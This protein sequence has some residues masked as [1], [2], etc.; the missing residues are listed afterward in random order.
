MKKIILSI[1]VLGF[2]LNA[3][4]Q[5]EKEP[6]ISPK[7]YIGLHAGTTTGYGLSYRYWPTKLGVELTTA[8]K[9]MPGNDYKISAGLS[10]LYTVLE[11]KYIGLYSYLGNSILSSNEG[12]SIYDSNT[13]ISTYENAKWTQYNIGL[14]MGFKVNL[15]KELDFNVQTGYGLYDITNDLRTN[16]TGE[17]SMYYH[18]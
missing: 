18:F 15:F 12:Y 11:N 8:P 7:H 6:Y 13:G 3:I 17:I 4:A 16:L 9:F 5:D 1:L 14:G 2:A 10:V